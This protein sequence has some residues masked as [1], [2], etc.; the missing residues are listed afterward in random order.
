MA[1]KIR[2]ARHGRKKRA[3]Y[4]IIVADSRAPRDGRF[5]EKIGT[6][7]PNTNP[8]TI[9]IDTDRAIDWLL[10]GAQPTDTARAILSYKGVMYKKHLLRGVEKGAL[11]EAEADKKFEGWLK[12]KEKKVQDKVDRLAK[13]KKDVEKKIFSAETEIKDAKEKAVIAKKSA[14]AEEV[15]AAEVTAA[16]AE[17]S[18]TE[19]E[20]AEDSVAETTEKTQESEESAKEEAPAAEETPVEKPVKE[21]APAAEETPAEEPA[22]EEAPAAE[23]TPTTDQ[24]PEEE[25]TEE[26]KG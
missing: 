20:S 7:N 1:V 22:K 2:L 12:D 3:F 8:A 4:H 14:L 21:E 6:Y 24:T 23:E 16:A 13:E 19:D 17:A 5:I 26:P 15:K 10:N 18:A 9:E 25:K 11:T